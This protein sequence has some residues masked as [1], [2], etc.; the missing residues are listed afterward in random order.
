MA[1]KKAPQI[2]LSE[3]PEI[4]DIKLV[5]EDDIVMMLC[6]NKKE[7]FVWDERDENNSKMLR[8]VSGGH[9][10]DITILAYDH[11]LSMVATGCING[12]ITLYDFEHS[13]VEGVLRGHTGDITGLEFLSPYPILISSSMDCT[14]CLWSIRPVP[15]KMLN[16]CFKRLIN[17]SWVFDEDKNVPI[18]KI[19]VWKDTMTG[20]KQY[21]KQ[22]ERQLR[23][24]AFRNFEHNFCF[25]F[26][27][28]EEMYQAEIRP[29]MLSYE[30]DLPYDEM[31]RK[32][33][34]TNIYQ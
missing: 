33:V 26:K 20:I 32:V 25:G 9:N 8:R 6:A 7:Y 19:K 28:V 21:R 31:F 27:T 13:K 23:A 17:S 14:V 5:W 16:V 24:S 10:E 12:E 22:R 34:K 18:T 30:P 2:N 15:T 11:H 3:N 4:F 1:Q 29:K